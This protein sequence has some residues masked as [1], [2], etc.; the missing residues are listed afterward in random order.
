MILV[1]LALCI[2]LVVVGI[3]VACISDDYCS[4]GLEFC[5][6]GATAIGIVG[7]VVSLIALVCLCVSVSNLK[8]ID[9][10]INMYQEENT[11][12]EQQI[13]TAVK[14]YQD[15]ESNIITECTPSS[16]IT[17][18]ALY[19]ELQADTLVQKQIDV[20]I[21]NNEKIKELKEKEINGSVTRW[22]LYFGG[23]K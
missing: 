10:K 5:G 19:P 6:C 13:D 9:E 4:E 18:V 7:V 11:K 2:V 20:Y 23:S 22:W 8:V 15:Y 1:I 12:I 21:Q 17:L 3:L 14:S 16:S